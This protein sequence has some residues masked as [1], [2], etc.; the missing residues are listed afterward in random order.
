MYKPPHQRN[1]RKEARKEFRNEFPELCKATV[2]TP[3]SFSHIKDIIEPEE[4]KIV[5]TNLISLKNPA[6]YRKPEIV[7]SEERVYEAFEKMVTRWEKNEHY[8]HYIETYPIEYSDESEESEEVSSLE[9]ED[10]EY[11]SDF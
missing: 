1:V 2:V 6:N 9:A 10:P 4:V 8:Q 5:P 7:F 3:M 11:E